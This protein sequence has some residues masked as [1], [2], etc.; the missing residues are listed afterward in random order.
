MWAFLD[1]KAEKAEKYKILYG[2]KLLPNPIKILVKMHQARKLFRLLKFIREIHT[3]RS[4]MKTPGEDEFAFYFTV[5]NKF[6]ESLHWFCDNISVL[7]DINVIKADSA[8]FSKLGAQMRFIALIFSFLLALRNVIH[9]AHKQMVIEKSLLTC[10]ESQM[11][12]LKAELKIIKQRKLDA[13]LKLLGIL[14]DLNVAG[15]FSGIGP[16]L[17]KVKFNEGFVAACGIISALIGCYF[18]Y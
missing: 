10:E 5:I 8:K 12:S 14:A 3:I 9:A 1:I 15:Q 2:K 17:F 11:D 4:L 7:S 13:W 16:K 18:T 6:W